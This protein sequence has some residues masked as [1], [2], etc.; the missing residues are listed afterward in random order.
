MTEFHPTSRQPMVPGTPACNQ[1]TSEQAARAIWWQQQ[2]EAERQAAQQQPPDPAHDQELYPWRQPPRPEPV[3]A[4]P[5]PRCW[6]FNPRWIAWVVVG[7]AL[8]WT[9]GVLID[10]VGGHAD[11]ADPAMYAIGA[12]VIAAVFFLIPRRRR[13]GS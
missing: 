11:P 13:K 12:T 5:Q 4:P 2:Q 9:V 7:F 6:R 8:I 10:G 3:A 1:V